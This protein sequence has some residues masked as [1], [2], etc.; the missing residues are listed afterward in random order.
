MAKVIKFDTSKFFR[1]SNLLKKVIKRKTI[2]AL[3]AVGAFAAGETKDRTPIDEGFLTEDV[4]YQVYPNENIVVIRIPI[5]APS[6]EYAIKMHEDSYNLG[7]RSAAKAQATGK[8]VGRKY[9]TRSLDEEKKP[10]K[11]I[12]KRE[13]SL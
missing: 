4:E 6:A 3:D 1:R 9:I 10:I 5:N 12:I 13:L 2:N 7:P 8:L 11:E